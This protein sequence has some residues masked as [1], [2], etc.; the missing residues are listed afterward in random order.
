MEETFIIRYD[1]ALIGFGGVNRAL[2]ELINERCVE[3]SRDFGLA[4]RVVAITDLRFGSLVQQEGI[5]LSTVLALSPEDG[6]FSQFRGGASELRNEWIIRSSSADIIVEATLTNPVDGQPA[7]SHVRWGLEAGKH[8]CTSNKGSVAFQGNALTALAARHHVRFEFEGTV[9]SGTPIIRLAKQEFHGL[10]IDRFE[11][12][13]NG[14][15][16]YVLGRLEDG[17]S[18][19]RQGN[20]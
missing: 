7:V 18:T 17:L 6:D 10:S 14:T 16:N 11:G 1:L 12:I 13:L 9:L 8:V 19:L 2:A 3:L 4:L 5:D 15:S 20:Q